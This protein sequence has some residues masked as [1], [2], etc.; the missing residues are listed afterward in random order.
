[1]EELNWERSSEGGMTQET[2]L[3]Q[4]IALLSL[5]AA[6]HF[7]CRIVRLGIPLST[8]SLLSY[9]ANI[10]SLAYVGRLSAHNLAAAVLGNRCVHACGF[11]ACL[12][13]MH[14]L[15]YCWASLQHVPP[16]QQP[17]QCHGIFRSDGPVI[18]HGDLVWSGEHWHEPPQNGDSRAD[19]HHLTAELWGWELRRSWRHSAALPSYLRHC[20]CHDHG[21]LDS[22][23]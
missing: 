9:T 19:S 21:P 17:L 12:L 15:Q 13:L 23:R 10:I 6:S 16:C 4:Q 2:S 1:M 8:V 20:V 7:C 5:A 11:L 3:P 14:S 18:C 22:D